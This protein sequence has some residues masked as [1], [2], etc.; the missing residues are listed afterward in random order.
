M[1]VTLEEA[2]ESA[3]WLEILIESRQTAGSAAR[4]LLR[5]AD[6]LSAILAASCI[7]AKLNAAR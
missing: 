3:F 1:G 6:E 2:D 4:V 5:E 7:T